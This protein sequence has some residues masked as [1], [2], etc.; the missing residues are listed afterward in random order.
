VK[1]FF[2]NIKQKVFYLIISFL[3]LS[4]KLHAQDSWN[5]RDDFFEVFNPVFQSAI[6]NNTEPIVKKNY[7]LKTKCFSFAR[8]AREK[9]GNGDKE[10]TRN[11]IL[12][13]EQ[14]TF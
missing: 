10:M 6:E 12:L 5:E 13:S 8:N 14:M 9:I 1:L 2:L 7:E 11:L 4:N 3:L